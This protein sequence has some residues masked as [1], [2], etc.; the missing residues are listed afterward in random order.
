MLATLLLKQLLRIVAATPMVVVAVLLFAAAP[1]ASAVKDDSYY[2]ANSGNPNMDLPMYWKDSENVLQD[3]SQF[4]ALYVEFHSCVWSWMKYPGA[5]DEGNSGS[6]DYANDYW[7][8]ES[9]PPMGANVAFSLY[10][11]L[12]GQTFDGCNRNSFINSFYTDFGFTDFARA[13]SYT[14][15][16]G[17]KGYTSNINADDDYSSSS[18]TTATCQGGYGVGCDSRYGFAMHKY[19]TDECDPQYY[20]GVSDTL[21]TLNNAMKGAQ[22]IK[23]FDAKSFAGFDYLFGTPLELLT[24]STACNYMNQQRPDGNCPDPYGK[25]AYYIKTFN[26]GIMKKR[27]DPWETYYTTVDRD[28]KMVVTGAALFAASVVIVLLEMTRRSKERGW[29][30]Y[31]PLLGNGSKGENKKKNCDD[32]DGDD[33][34]TVTSEKDGVNSDEQIKTSSTAMSPP[35]ESKGVPTISGQSLHQLATAFQ[36][37]V[38]NMFQDSSSNKAAPDV[39][40]VNATHYPDIGMAASYD[41]ILVTTSY[42]S[43]GRDWPGLDGPGSSGHLGRSNDRPPSM[44]HNDKNITPPPLVDP[45]QIRKMLLEKLA[46]HQAEKQANTVEVVAPVVKTPSTGQEDK[47][48]NTQ[49][50]TGKDANAAKAAAV[51]RS[52]SPNRSINKKDGKGG[53]TGRVTPPAT[54]AAKYTPPSLPTSIQ[55]KPAG[56]EV[57]ITKAAQ[58]KDKNDNKPNLDQD[59]SDTKGSKEPTA[60]RVS[61]PTA[62]SSMNRSSKTNVVS[63]SKTTTDDKGEAGQ[64]VDKLAA[65]PVVPA[66]AVAAV[67]PPLE[68]TNSVLEAI[69]RRKRQAQPQQSNLDVVPVIIAT[70]SMSHDTNNEPKDDEKDAKADTKDTTTTAGAAEISEPVMMPPPPSD[71]SMGDIKTSTTGVSKPIITVPLNTTTGGVK[72]TTTDV[73]TGVAKKPVI[74]TTPP[75]SYKSSSCMVGEIKSSRS[76]DSY[77][78][79]T[80]TSEKSN[81]IGAAAAPGRGRA[82]SPV[83]AAK[84]VVITT[85]PPISYKR[86]TS[87]GGGDIKS[88]LSSDS[89]SSTTS[90]ESKIG[91]VRF[92]SSPPVPASYTPPLPYQNRA[93]SPVLLAAAAPPLPHQQNRASSPVINAPPL[94]YQNRASS[95][96]VRTK[97]PSPTMDGPPSI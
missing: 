34:I 83:P 42:Q 19:S 52:K 47:N 36:P 20:S 92:P 29:C 15:L 25:I 91:G 84:P 7:Y 49:P 6:G 72:D 89:Y 33:G 60:K 21:S 53:G 32:D 50:T 41:P 82:A 63:L 86:S 88:T 67:I 11:A 76:S 54:T 27:E 71:K 87:M 65:A 14:G 96:V 77:L 55:Q 37:G 70:P 97:S 66:A 80:K 28:L 3:L 64:V 90:I 85:R 26:Q 35:T 8:T 51:S 9:V 17:F 12:A 59:V 13:M 1:F 30:C 75:I 43:M 16:S 79:S 24:Y 5:V 2:N 57:P 40:G 31:A 45:V 23:I 68:M 69:A 22:C 46:R 39:R 95:P 93:N 94:P 81:K 73:S 48:N 18:G 62:F 4:S 38:H 10:G 44:D 56:L 78:S 58:D 61:S 74:T